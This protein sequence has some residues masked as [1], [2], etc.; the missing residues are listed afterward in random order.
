MTVLEFPPGFLWGA[1]TSAYQIEGAVAA[2][3]RGPSI[4]DTFCRVPGAVIGGGTGDVACDHYRRYADD[5]A[6]MADLGLPG[7]RFSIAWPRV[8]PGG[9]GPANSAGL[10]FYDRLVDTL[11]GR[12]IT[13]M[14]T[15]YHWDL[16]QQLQD[17]GG[18]T[19]RSTA[20]RFATYA[21][22]VARC[23]GDRVRLW[24]T[25]NE[26]WCSAFLG[27][28]SG[29]H[30]PGIRDHRQSLQAVHHLLLAHGLAAR[31][32]RST[33]PASAQISITLN[34]HQVDPASADPV[35]LAA[36]HRIDG[37][38]NRIFLDPLFHGRYPDDVLAST[39]HLTD[40]SF[41]RDGDLDLIAVPIDALGVNYYTPVTVSGRATGP[42]AADPAEEKHGGVSAFPGC[43]G[44][45]MIKQ[46][47]R[48][49]DMDWLI[50]P[51]GLTRLLV[52]LSGDLPGVPLFVTENG[53]AYHA[54]P[55]ANGGRIRDEARIE[56]LRGHISAVHDAIRA[57]ADVRGYF[58]WS[59]LD[60]FEWAWGYSQRFGLV[61]VDYETGERI[62]KQSATWLRDLIEANGLPTA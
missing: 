14:L 39:A 46:P 30:A 27:Y 8:Q 13:P 57:G 1:A 62:P 22:I 41:V 17:G 48:R 11:L 60:N 36:A 7:Y 23:L 61:Y 38:A 49:T 43:D 47:G 58:V 56:Y 20:E 44:L 40:W 54:P 45:R 5:V 35:D 59:L 9:S 32:L 4:W 33:L 15:L 19:V 25:V 53:A 3:G 12:G 26:P 50:D 51:A 6:L 24:T 21:E 52:R 37:V 42:E 16:P 34:P 55:G 10:A 31:V 18:W 2:G 28:A 29:V